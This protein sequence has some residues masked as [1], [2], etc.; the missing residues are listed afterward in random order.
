MENGV[1]RLRALISTAVAATN[2]LKVGELE[3]RL[4]TLQAAI[5]GTRPDETVA[6]PAETPAEAPR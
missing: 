5:G 4:A 1:P 2:L 6:F 3:E